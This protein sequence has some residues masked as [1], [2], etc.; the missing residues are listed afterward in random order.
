MG[1]EIQPFEQFLAT[2]RRRGRKQRDGERMEIRETRIRKK[3]DK[4]STRTF[5]SLGQTYPICPALMD[6]ATRLP[7]FLDI[8]T[9]VR[10]LHRAFARL[11]ALTWRSSCNGARPALL[12]G[13][14]MGEGERGMGKK[15]RKE[16]V[17]EGGEVVKKSGRE[18][19]S[20]TDQLKGI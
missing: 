7:A 19:A 16:G 11:R 17:G 3:E 8:L 2:R 12:Q 15:G 6:P 13:K 20:G 4:S 1:P 5:S 18:R 9:F 10:F 14:A